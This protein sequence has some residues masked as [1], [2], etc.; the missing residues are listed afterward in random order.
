MLDIYPKGGWESSDSTGKER[1]AK[2]LV[3][4]YGQYGADV[5]MHTVRTPWWNPPIILNGMACLQAQN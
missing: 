5:T 4:F 2:G 1:R 3:S